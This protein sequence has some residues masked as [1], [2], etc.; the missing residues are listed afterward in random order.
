FCAHTLHKILRHHP[1]ARG[2][3]RSII[4]EPFTPWGIGIE[5]HDRDSGIDRLIDRFLER[6]GIID[7]NRDAIH[8]PLNEALDDLRLLDGIRLHRSKPLDLDL[9]SPEVLGGRLSS[10]PGKLENGVIEQFRNE[11][12]DDLLLLRAAG[13]KQD[14][15]KKRGET[16]SHGSI[17]S[18]L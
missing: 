11:S 10:L 4:R 15:C 1:A 9:A 17:P 16:I 18:G 6:I 2:V 5:R 7:R 3:S 12:K 8:L 14:T 13:E